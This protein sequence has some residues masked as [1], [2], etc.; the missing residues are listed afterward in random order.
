[1]DK[2]TCF[3]PSASP[4]AAYFAVCDGYRAFPRRPR[5]RRAVRPLKTIATGSATHLDVKADVDRFPRGITRRPNI[6]SATLIWEKS[7]LLGPR[8]FRFPVPS[9]QRGRLGLAAAFTPKSFTRHGFPFCASCP[10]LA[11]YQPLSG[12]AGGS[13]YWRRDENED[14]DNQHDG[15]GGGG[16]ARLAQSPGAR[17]GSTRRR[18][19]VA[20]DPVHLTSELISRSQ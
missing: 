14:E 4:S 8:K 6:L 2:A 5:S 13:K 11:H 7:F 10:Y 9:L 12:L 17:P 1:M 19:R 18:A 16:K 3:R 20:V 15:A